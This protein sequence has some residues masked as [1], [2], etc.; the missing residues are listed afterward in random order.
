MGKPPLGWLPG[1]LAAVA[2][3]PGGSSALPGR[4]GPLQLQLQQLPGS[5]C[6]APFLLLIASFSLETFSSNPVLPENLP[7]NDALFT[8]PLQMSASL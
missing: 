5:T 7:Q 1:G 2:G 6:P 4:H 3:S 8:L